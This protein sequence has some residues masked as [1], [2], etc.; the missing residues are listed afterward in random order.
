MRVLVGGCWGPWDMFSLLQA[1][2]GKVFKNSYA[3][4]K[5]YIVCVY[6]INTNGGLAFRLTSYFS[7][8]YQFTAKQTGD[9]IKESHQLGDVLYAP[10]NSLN[11]LEGIHGNK[12]GELIF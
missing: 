6:F 10:P 12:K 2:C 1:G 8:R 3:F 9:K 11:S 5:M 7:Y 4:T